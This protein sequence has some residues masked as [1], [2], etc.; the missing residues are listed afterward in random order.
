MTDENNIPTIHLRD[1]TRTL[2]D[3]LDNENEFKSHWFKFFTGNGNL[4]T[5]DKG[6]TISL[7]QKNTKELAKSRMLRNIKDDITGKECVVNLRL[8]IGFNNMIVRY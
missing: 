3:Q 4:H 2:Q 1:V 8:L 5:I 7:P 6:H